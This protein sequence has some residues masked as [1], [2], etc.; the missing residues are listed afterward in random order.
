MQKF[1]SESQ[2]DDTKQILLMF[3]GGASNAS[4]IITHW[5]TKKLP[6]QS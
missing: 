2:S 4:D 6:N 1:F 3:L 5:K